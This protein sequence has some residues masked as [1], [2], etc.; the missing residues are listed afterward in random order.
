MNST[1]KT[2]IVF[3]LGSGSKLN[4]LEL[5]FSLRSVMKHGLN[6][7][8][9]FIVGEKPHFLNWGDRLIHIPFAES[10]GRYANIWEKAK[11][12][13]EDERISEKIVWFNDDMYVLQDFDA[14]AIPFFSRAR[15]I[16][17]T[18]SGTSSY[19]KTFRMTAAALKQRGCTLYHYGTHQPC[20]LSVIDRIGREAVLIVFALPLRIDHVDLPE[21]V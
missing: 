6:V 19:Q 14:G 18:K 11:A 17:L 21:S 2:D 20:N 1:E 10:C 5:R 13:A 15:Q 12:V 3:P 16:D 8:R 9:V 4:N 7:G